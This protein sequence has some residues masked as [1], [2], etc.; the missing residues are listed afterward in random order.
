M[1]LPPIIVNQKAENVS[2][3]MIGV[4]IIYRGK[5]VIVPTP[6]AFAAHRAAL[7]ARPEYNQWAGA[8]YLTETGSSLAGSKSLPLHATQYDDQPNGHYERRDLLEIIRS[9]ERLL[10]L[11]EPGMGKTVALQRMMWETASHP[12]P[13]PLPIFVPLNMFEGDLVETVRL[14]LRETGK[15]RFDPAALPNA[16]PSTRESAESVL[17]AYRSLVTRACLD[18]EQCLILFDGLNETPGEWRSKIVPALRKFMTEF[19]Q[20]RYV[21]TSRLQDPLWDTLRTKKGSL[22]SETVVIQP[23]TTDQIWKY[24]VEHLDEANGAALYG[25]LNDRLLE[26]ARTPLML[27]MI[28]KIGRDTPELPRNRGQL[29]KQCVNWILEREMLLEFTTPPETQKQAL[30]CLAFRLQTEHRLVCPRAHAEQ[31]VAETT[32]GHAAETVVEDALVH[33]LLQLARALPEHSTGWQ[34]ALALVQVAVRGVPPTPAPDTD[35]PQVKF[36]HQ[37]FQE[38]FAS[39]DLETA[40][41]MEKQLPGWLRWRLGKHRIASRARD[42]WWMETFVQLAGLT[43][44]ANWLALE[45]ARNGSPFLAWW[46]IDEGGQVDE[47]TRRLVEQNSVGLLQAPKPGDRQRAVRALARI[48]SERV[49]PLLLLAAGDE[50]GSVYK[51]ALQ[52]LMQHEKEKVRPP[53]EQAL[54]S[55]DSRLRRGGLRFLIV[56]PVNSWAAR[57]TFHLAADD[58]PEIGNLAAQA[59]AKMGDATHPLLEQ[60]LNGD[61][62]RSWRA[63]LRHLTRLPRH[64]LFAK[65]PDKVWKGVLGHEMVCVPPGPFLMGS[66]KAKDSQAFDRELPQHTVTL[67]GYWIGRYLVTVAQWRI[68]VTE[69]GHKPED[70]RSLKDPDTHPVCYVDWYEGRDY[71]RWWS[72][73]TGLAIQLPSEA[74]WEKAARGPSTGSGDGRIYPWGDAFDKDKCNTSESGIGT[75]T[76]VGQ[77]SPQGDSP[78]GC[79]DMIG[80]VWEWTRSLYKPYPYQA[81]DGREDATANGARAQRGGSWVSSRDYARAAYRDPFNPNGRNGGGGFRVSWLPGR[82][83]NGL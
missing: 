26:L 64:P 62:R 67:P 46:C 56:Q 27:W 7:A 5:E 49:L 82:A 1:D 13:A 34:R 22:I 71:C 12:Q 16:A 40:L 54:N 79:A 72:Q 25:R 45:L 37:Y 35:S 74:E 52:A 68:Y 36:A 11:G 81:N 80:N 14:G 10:I 38:Y 65:I 61:D 29:F 70:D 39:L 24:L 31:L 30:R 57:V 83:D 21:I 50:D 9:H 51:P 2:G 4:Q 48:S 66:D 28:Q 20:H 78:Y 73:K 23:I 75:T 41:Q 33:N 8:F 63:A 3:Q 58:D 69:S 19:P 76:P 43:Q 32:G 44:D 42:A 6:E 55:E 77:Y 15:L 59:L 60:A 53:L 18:R 47:S 17:D